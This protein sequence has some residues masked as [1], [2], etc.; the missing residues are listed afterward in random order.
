MD[1]LGLVETR[2]IVQGVKAMDKM[3]KAAPVALV[4]GTGICSGRYMIQVAG[5]QADVEEALVRAK[6]EEPFPVDVRIL[7]R[8]SSQVL[9]ALK[10][11]ASLPRESAMG[12]VESRRAIAGIAAADAA[13]KQADVIL[14]RLTVANGINGKSYLVLGGNV[15]AVEEGV[16]AAGLALGKDLVDRLVLPSP[17][18]S[19]I[20]ALCPLDPCAGCKEI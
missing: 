8:V 20:R 7:S 12:V 2:T 11:Q 18:S 14:A 9:A 1:A 16:E 4:K 17:D 19:T 15:A 13:V 10:K 6:D 3:L 5:F